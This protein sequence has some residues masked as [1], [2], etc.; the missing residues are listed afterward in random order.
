MCVR[1]AGS[2]I[3]L[4]RIAG[5]AH[6]FA[7][8]ICLAASGCMTLGD[9]V[10]PPTVPSDTPPMEAKPASLMTMEPAVPAHPRPRKPTH[11]VRE[12][13]PSHHD[14]PVAAAKPAAAFNPDKLIGLTPS[15]VEKLIGSPSQVKDD[16]L[17]R[18]WVYSGSGC[19][20]RVF[21]Y[22]NLNA[23]SFR[24]LKYGGSDSNGGMLAASN[25]CVRRILTARA[26]AT[27]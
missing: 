1:I 2:R 11:E 5:R 9:Q 21:F 20:F 10:P 26:N 23:A 27:D 13:E 16:H 12:P 18:E 19:N 17:S 4:I 14:R 15:D 24:A 6:G 3:G 22:P 7:I 8:L 25:A